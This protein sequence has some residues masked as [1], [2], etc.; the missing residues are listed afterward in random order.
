MR[1]PV[2]WTRKATEQAQVLFKG[3]RCQILSM[4]HSNESLCTI[5]WKRPTCCFT[6][7]YIYTHMYIFLKCRFAA[8]PPP[9]TLVFLLVSLLFATERYPLK[10]ARLSP[11]SPE[12]IDPSYPKMA[13]STGSLMPRVLGNQISKGSRRPQAP[14]ALRS[15]VGESG[16]HN[17]PIWV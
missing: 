3:S 1:Q 10:K 4:G 6:R 11:E 7:E 8:D 12:R 16:W 5:Q 9:Q 14:S 2:D 13:P 15:R 17:S